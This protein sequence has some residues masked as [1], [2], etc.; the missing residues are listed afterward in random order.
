MATTEE[1]ASLEFEAKINSL[2]A[3]ASRLREKCNQL[4]EPNPVTINL[5]SPLSLSGERPNKCVEGGFDVWSWAHVKM[6]AHL[7]LR[8][9]YFFTSNFEL[10]KILTLSWD[11]NLA[12]CLHQSPLTPELEERINFYK[13]FSPKELQVEKLM[14]RKN[15]WEGDSD[16]FKDAITV[17]TTEEA[18]KAVKAN[19]QWLE[20]WRRQFLEGLSE[21]KELSIRF[22][23]SATTSYRLRVDR[24]AMMARMDLMYVA[25]SMRTQ[26]NIANVERRREEVERAFTQE[27]AKMEA[28]IKKR[29]PE[30]FDKSLACENKATK[31]EKDLGDRYKDLHSKA[32]TRIKEFEANSKQAKPYIQEKDKMIDILSQEYGRKAQI[33]EEKFIN[34]TTLEEKAKLHIDLQ[35][36][37]DAAKVEAFKRAK[38]AEGKLATLS[39]VVD[40]SQKR[41][42]KMEGESSNLKGCLQEQEP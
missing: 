24:F 34:E 14:T 3:S 15:L 38:E 13:S 26:A 21:A 18:L 22:K 20:D 29:V 32:L 11:F 28:T 2:I 33:I 36:K 31:I 10:R 37:V 16:E 42:T 39:K 7:P 40:E 4:P 17:I 9:F 1:I 8:E 12:N 6:R 41:I 5:T 19:E 27:N 35:Q 30:S 25:D 23:E